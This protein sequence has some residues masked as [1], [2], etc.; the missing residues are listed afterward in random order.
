MESSNSAKILLKSFFYAVYNQLY[1]NE[2]YDVI[3]QNKEFFVTI[4]TS[5]I[6]R[7]KEGF[8]QFTKNFIAQTINL[9]S[10]ISKHLAF[11]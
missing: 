2:Y 7:S 3:I 8:R 6:V 5:R 4:L 11:E 9:K 10:I 1:N